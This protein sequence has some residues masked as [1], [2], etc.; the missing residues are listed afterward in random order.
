MALTSNNKSAK[1]NFSQL[2][3]N[4][5]DEPKVVKPPVEEKK[6]EKPAKIEENPV[7]EPIPED[8]KPIENTV[9]EPVLEGREV[10]SLSERLAAQAKKTRGYQKSI[11]FDEDTYTYVMS[12]AEKY[13]IRISQVIN[14]MIRD[15]KSKEN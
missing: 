8:I 7:V 11:Y 1:I 9:Q 3:D 13:N 12:I 15:I 10:S 5:T 2:V 6:P 4:I 14:S